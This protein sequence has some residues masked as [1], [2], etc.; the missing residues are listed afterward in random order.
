M[1]NL[2]LDGPL[3]YTIRRYRGERSFFLGIAGQNITG[4]RRPLL[5]HSAADLSVSQEGFD[6]DIGKKA[7]T[8]DDT[9]KKKKEKN[10]GYNKSEKQNHCTRS[11]QSCHLFM[12][13]CLFPINTPHQWAVLM[14]DPSYAAFVSL[15][16]ARATLFL[17]AFP[18][19]FALA[20]FLFLF[21]V[22]QL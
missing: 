11:Q 7:K 16:P 15:P 14:F 17:R 1:I 19:P 10:V 4:K 6:V 5:T 22:Q 8:E 21:T 20:V 13:L 18:L 12:C 3:G 9:L 2:G